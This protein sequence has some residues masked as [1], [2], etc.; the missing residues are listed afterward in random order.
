MPFGVLEVDS[1]NPAN[2]MLQMPTSSQASPD[3]SVLPLSA[4]M[5]TQVSGKHSP[6]RPC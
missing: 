1:P 4:N 6:I 2:S 5:P 3:F